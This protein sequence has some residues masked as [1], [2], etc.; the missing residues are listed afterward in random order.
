MATL[1]VGLM[2]IFGA[3][4]AYSE[5]D[6]EFALPSPFT[7]ALQTSSADSGPE[8]QLVAL[9]QNGAAS[10]GQPDPN[11]DPDPGATDFRG[12]FL[13]TPDPT[14]APPAGTQPAAGSASAAL[15]QFTIRVGKSMIPHG[16]DD[17]SEEFQVGGLFNPFVRRF[18][19]PAQ[20]PYPY[21]MGWSKYDEASIM[22]QAHTNGV[23]GS[24]G[25]VSWN[26]SVQ[27]AQKLTDG[28]IFTWTGVTNS[29]YLTGPSGLALPGQVDLLAS[30]FEITAQGW[31]P[32]S[33]QF[34]F[35][36]QLATNF[37][38]S[39]N[40]HAYNWDGRAVAYYQS[41]PT[42]M[43]AL[44]AAFWNRVNNYI[45]PH[46]GVIWLP[47]DRWELRLLFPKSQIIYLLGDC[48]G[49]TFWLYTSC[50]YNIESYQISIGDP[51]LKNRMQLSDYRLLVGV[52]SRYGRVTSFLEGGWVFNRQV[53]FQDSAANFDIADG[54]MARMGLKF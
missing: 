11:A 32:W 54:P 10:S 1:F 26:A 7:R 49:T 38:Q 23:A 50:E 24:I 13:S 37:E 18:P 22:P 27:Y 39:I 9:K 36:P 28:L 12:R 47:T 21:R 6:A 34:A 29:S 43:I 25:F 53:R 48:W 33:A 31:G 35:T 51:G 4:P 15:Q 16:Y 2:L 42:L 45:V 30:D 5:R 8:L 41:S 44:G 40:S 17:Y 14:Q 20:G 19:F 3:D 46:A 52:N